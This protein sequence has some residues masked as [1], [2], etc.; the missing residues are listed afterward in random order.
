MRQRQRPLARLA[1]A[2]VV[3][4][5][6]PLLSGC[7]SINSWPNTVSSAFDNLD[8]W[9]TKK[10]LPGERK[11]V[12]PEGVPGVSTGVPPEMTKG[13]RESE[14]GAA[15]PAKAAAEA[16][17]AEQNPKPKPQRTASKPPPKPKPPADASASAPPAASAQSGAQP[18]PQTA[19]APWPSA[20]S[21]QQSQA[22][23]PGQQGTAR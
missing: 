22:P 9:D 12:F 10:K 20:P 17:A 19:A 16:A 18:A 8:F 6:G 15:D 3:V 5:T 23:W 14:Q 13:Y 11:P 21:A 7:E 4:A 1:L 2:A